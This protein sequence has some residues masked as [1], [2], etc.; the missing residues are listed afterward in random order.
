[1]FLFRKPAPSFIR[2]FLDVQGKL[3]LTYPAVGATAADP[4][5]GFV[6][7]HTRIKLGTD[8]VAFTAAKDALQRWEQFRL[9]WVEQYSPDTPIEPGQVVGVLGRFC[10]QWSLNACR[11]VY[12]VNEPSKFGF[13]YGTLPDHVA[14]GEERFTVEWHE[15]DEAVW[16]EILAF[17]RQNHFLA[18]LGYPVVRRLQKGSS[19][20]SALW[21]M[22]RAECGSSNEGIFGSVQSKDFELEERAIAEAVCLALHGLD[23]VIDTFQRPR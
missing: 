2:A 5:L 21:A 9:G 11:I 22:T 13:A 8:Q 16:Y 15:E 10:R 1:M 4:P 23:L 20:P 18:R 17:S 19:E 7:D 6:V 14:S 12:V 3:N